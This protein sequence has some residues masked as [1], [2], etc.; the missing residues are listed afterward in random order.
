MAPSDGGKKPPQKRLAAKRSFLARYPR[1]IVVAIGVTGIWR[2]RQGNLLPDPQNRYEIAVD[3]SLVPELREFMRFTCCH[4]EQ[5][6]LYFYPSYSRNPD[7]LSLNRRRARLA[8]PMVSRILRPD[9][10]RLAVP[11]EGQA[12][13]LLPVHHELAVTRRAKR[14]V[15]TA[16]LH[17][18]PTG[19]ENVASQDVASQWLFRTWRQAE[20]PCCLKSMADEALR[21]LPEFG[22]QVF[23]HLV[24]GKQVGAIGHQREKRFALPVVACRSKQIRDPHLSSVSGVSSA[25]GGFGHVPCICPQSRQSLNST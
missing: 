21:A 22:D 5:E 11:V 25:M 23:G 12:V 19:M 20:A 16:S 4:F 15:E 8:D 17:A 6:E 1:T 9:G 24:V 14:L 10:V 2:N 3:D 13:A 18:D 7:P